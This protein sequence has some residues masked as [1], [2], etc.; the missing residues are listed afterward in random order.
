MLEVAVVKYLMP[1]PLR[2][3]SFWLIGKVCNVRWITSGIKSSLKVIPYN[4]FS[5]W[6]VSSKMFLRWLW[7]Q[8]GYHQRRFTTTYWFQCL[9]N[10][11]AHRLVE[12]GLISNFDSCW[13]EQLPNIILIILL[14]ACM[15][16]NVHN[17]TN[18]VSSKKTIL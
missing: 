12:L 13:F 16:L 10:C 9:S 7:L 3:W 17:K 11:V 15:H 4:L 2:W 18:S 5:H 6:A 1:Q 8:R 14:G